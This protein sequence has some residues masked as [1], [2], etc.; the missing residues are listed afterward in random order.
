MSEETYE[1]KM[2][3]KEKLRLQFLETLVQQ[4][5]NNTNSGKGDDQI[6]ILYPIFSGLG[7]NMA[8]LAEA[9]LVSFLT[10]RRFYC[11]V[12]LYGVIN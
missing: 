6:L 5:K 1:E 12:P 4:Q 11:I 7:N 3:K 2:E 10:N 8:V 9:I